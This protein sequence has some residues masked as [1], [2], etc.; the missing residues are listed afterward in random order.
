MSRLCHWCLLLLRVRPPDPPRLPRPCVPHPRRRS[1]RP[2]VAVR[3]PSC[4]SSAT[5]SSPASRCSP[6]G[7]KAASRCCTTHSRNWRRSGCVVGV[8]SSRAWA[9]PSSRSPARSSACAPVDRRWPGRGSRRRDAPAVTLAHTRARRR[10]PGAALRRRAPLAKRE[11]QDRRPA[12]VAGAYVVLVERSSRRCMSS[13][14]G[15]VW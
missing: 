13:A 3:S 7:S 6:R 15:A 4:C 10:R 2:S 12:R 14:A 1:P 11:G 8:T 5:G 9:A